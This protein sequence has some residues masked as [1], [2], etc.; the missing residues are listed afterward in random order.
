[1]VLCRLSV[2][3][4]KNIKGFLQCIRLTIDRPPF[5]YYYCYWKMI[6]K[7]MY[8]VINS[9]IKLRKCLFKNEFGARFMRIRSKLNIFCNLTCYSVNPNLPQ[10]DLNLFQ[11]IFEWIKKCIFIVRIECSVVVVVVVKNK[12]KMLQMKNSVV[13]L[14]SIKTACVG[15]CSRWHFSLDYNYKLRKKRRRR[16]KMK[17]KLC[18][19]RF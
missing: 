15:F 19:F 5:N 17:W 16:K 4:R 13:I 3:R 10:S 1:M 7:Q 12:N 6:G 11:F 14:I 8:L 2:S 18:Q 9:S